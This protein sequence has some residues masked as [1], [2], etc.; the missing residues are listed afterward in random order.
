MLMENEVVMLVMGIGVLIFILLSLPQIKK[1]NFWKIIFV[2]YVIL[3][4]GLLFTNLEEYILPDFL[5]YCEHLSYLI[6]SVLLVI[7]CWKTF[8]LLRGG[9]IR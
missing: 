2:S 1:I 4:L 6:S 8:Q 9:D 7:W 3:L 5:N